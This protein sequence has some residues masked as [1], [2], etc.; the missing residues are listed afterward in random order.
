MVLNAERVAGG[1]ALIQDY[2]PGAFPI[3]FR[4]H[5]FP[6]LAINRF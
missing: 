5:P 3:V 2:W 4:I 6:T 1:F